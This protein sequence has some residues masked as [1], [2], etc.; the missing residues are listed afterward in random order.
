MRRPYTIIV[1]CVDDVNIEQETDQLLF[2]LLHA[3]SSQVDDV[4]TAAITRRTSGGVKP[5]VG[6]DVK[7]W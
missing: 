3:G 2:R 6:S 1:R 4:T 7:V 5:E